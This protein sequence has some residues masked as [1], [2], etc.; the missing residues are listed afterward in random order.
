[1]FFWSSLRNNRSQSRFARPKTTRS[2]ENVSVPGLIKVGRVDRPCMMRDL[3]TSGVIVEFVKD[4]PPELPQFFY[5]KSQNERV[6]RRGRLIWQHRKQAG[7]EFITNWA[8]Q[9]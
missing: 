4:L 1:M 8:T 3:T 9:S 7:V 6:F 5:L 2:A